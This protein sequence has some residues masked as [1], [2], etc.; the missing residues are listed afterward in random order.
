MEYKCKLQ[1][2]NF[3]HIEGTNFTMLFVLIL[4]NL[5][6]FV[7]NFQIRVLSSNLY[8]KKQTHIYNKMTKPRKAIRYNFSDNV[9]LIKTSVI[10]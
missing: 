2:I 6:E 9:V 8:M 7:F 10:F 4:V 3:K 1:M 5:N